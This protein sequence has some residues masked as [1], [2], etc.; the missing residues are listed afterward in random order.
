M[1]SEVSWK[2]LNVSRRFLAGKY[3]VTSMKKLKFS[4]VIAFW[5]F[6]FL[7][8]LSLIAV[9][10]HSTLNDIAVWED[11]YYCPE[12]L[13]RGLLVAGFAL[14]FLS[15]TS[16]I[17]FAVL[18]LMSNRVKLWGK[19]FLGYDKALK[20][21]SR[22]WSILIVLGVLLLSAS[23]LVNWIFDFEYGLSPLFLYLIYQGFV[24]VVM[25]VFIMF[26]IHYLK[27]SEHLKSYK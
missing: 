22:L 18:H 9:A 21:L 27:K 16:I 12:D 20:G 13:N 1:N 15:M 17:L 11:F 26:L 4:L 5:T 25:G 24:L 19:P 7:I 3:I 6:L 23:L 10:V 14:C 2:K 8:S